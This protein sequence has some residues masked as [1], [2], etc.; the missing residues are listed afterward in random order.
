MIEAIPAPGSAGTTA[1]SGLSALQD[2]AAQAGFGLDIE[3]GPDSTRFDWHVHA[4]VP[5]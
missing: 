1:A 4:T 2:K 3:P 5:R